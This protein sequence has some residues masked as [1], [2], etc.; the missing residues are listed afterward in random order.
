MSADLTSRMVYLLGRLRRE[1]N[2]A[3]VEA[4][5]Q[6]G[7]AGPLNY[8]VSIPA[9]R[10]IAAEAGSD[11]RF[12]RF[13]YSQQVRELR[14][15]ALS[16]AEP[17]KVRADEID[18]WLLDNSSLELLDELALRLLSRCREDVLRAVADRW[19]CSDDL[20]R[21]YAAIMTLARVRGEMLASAAPGVQAVLLRF[22]TE[23]NIAR[24]VVAYGCSLSAEPAFGDWMAS[25]P[26]TP[27]GRV[28]S[29]E[30]TALFG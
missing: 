1:M 16:I 21:C 30:L 22:P 24:A 20:N 6:A 14:M 27:S 19:L 13:L 29:E 28:V 9:I 17:E 8:G 10:S 5:E 2:G 11:H 26:D 23:R 4:M 18:E 3:V 7:V 15:A 12:A 25:L